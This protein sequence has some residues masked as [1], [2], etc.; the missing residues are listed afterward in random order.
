MPSLFSALLA[1][2]TCL[3]FLFS[4]VTGNVLP[5]S[6]YITFRDI[7]VAEAGG[8]HNVHIEY[9][10]PIDGTLSIH[11]G[12]CGLPHHSKVHH[13]LGRAHVGSYPLAKRYAE[14]SDQ[15]P[16]RFVWLPPA[17]APS[18]GCLHAY[19]E[20]ELVGRSSPLTMTRRQTKRGTAFADV[21]DAMGPWFDGVQYLSEK[22]PDEVFAAKTKSS[23][24]GIIGGGMSG[25]M[26]SVWRT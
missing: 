4:A 24:F 26:T 5:R 11:F 14:W 10:G 22:E 16:T 25:L 6:T 8:I 2:G 3:P 21:A 17:D 1:S 13:R 12:S 18:G 15:R 9:N 20:D 23:K 19:I 7:D